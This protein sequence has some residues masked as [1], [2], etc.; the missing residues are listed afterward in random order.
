MLA[1]IY[2]RTHLVPMV[3]VSVSANK[4]VEVHLHRANLEWL[5]HRSYFFTTTIRMRWEGMWRQLIPN[6]SGASATMLHS[7]I[8]FNSMRLISIRGFLMRPDYMR[9]GDK[10]VANGE[11]GASTTIRCLSS[12]HPTQR[13]DRLLNGLRL[14]Q[15]QPSLAPATL[16]TTNWCHSAVCKS[17][18]S[19]CGANAE[20]LCAR[21]ECAAPCRGILIINWFVVDNL[22]IYLLLVC[23][24]NFRK[25]NKSLQHYIWMAEM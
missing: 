6:F 16:K 12:F 25:I 2:R 19:S 14:N 9:M 8:M 21:T 1:N 5:P 3:K 7:N 18:A 11:T 15:F 23:S 24:R 17:S 4:F 22:T 13:W 20:C 10:C